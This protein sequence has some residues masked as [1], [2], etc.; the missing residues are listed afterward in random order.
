MV[1]ALFQAAVLMTGQLCKIRSR[2]KQLL[3]DHG[4]SKGSDK[5]EFQRMGRVRVRKNRPSHKEPQ[6]RVPGS[7]DST[8]QPKCTK[9]SPTCVIS[10]SFSIAVKPK[11]LISTLQEIPVDHINIRISY[12]GSKAPY[13]EDIR[14]HLL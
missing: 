2:K 3:K 9:R 14:N 5:F 4:V 1:L 8:P 6:E 13:K 12:P 11:A 10:L 7:L